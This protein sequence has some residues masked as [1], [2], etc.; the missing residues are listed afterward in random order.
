MANS[1]THIATHLRKPETG[2]WWLSVEDEDGVPIKTLRVRQ[3]TSFDDRLD[4]VGPILNSWGW[5]YN[6]AAMWSD[7][8]DGNGWSV[9]VLNHR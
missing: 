5:Y 7:R 9:A 3:F 4:L 8:V 2:E 6:G 1:N